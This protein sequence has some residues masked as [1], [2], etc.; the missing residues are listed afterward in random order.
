MKSVLISIQPYYVFL[1]IAQL[2][3]WDIPQRK[4][5]EVRKDLPKDKAWDRVTHIYCSKN[6]KSFKQI[7]AKYQPLMEKY[8]GKVVGLFICDNIRKGRGDNAIAAYYH[9]NP[10]ETCL[11]DLEL[12]LYATV[13]KP[14]YFWHI[15]ALKIYE[16]PKE[17]GEF[18]KP[19]KWYEKGD[20]P[21]CFLC[22]KSGYTPDMQFD[23]FNTLKIPP[24][25]WYYTEA[26]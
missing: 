21:D 23:C 17:L 24:Q 5:E 20:E 1:I 12:R 19:C 10:D 9:N 6:R 22:D 15:S 16:K 2:M 14:L 13:G 26:I 25:S 7:P 11:T 4:T 8:L 18:R 3:G